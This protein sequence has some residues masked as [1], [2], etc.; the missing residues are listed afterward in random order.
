MHMFHRHPWTKDRNL[1]QAVLAGACKDST[2]IFSPED[3][4]PFPHMPPSM[5]KG[6]CRVRRQE[7]E[8]TEEVE[9]ENCGSL[10]GRWDVECA[11]ERKRTGKAVGARRI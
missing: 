2:A 11:Y 1:Q 3:G 8:Q 9:G 5:R 7:M 10:R 6:R 4:T